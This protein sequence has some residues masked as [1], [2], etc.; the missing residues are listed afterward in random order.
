MFIRIF[1][2]ALSSRPNPEQVTL[3]VGVELSVINS[4]P[5]GLMSPA[6]GQVQMVAVSAEK[7]VERASPHVPPVT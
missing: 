6:G 4:H 2:M 7:G 1:A 3:T 5:Q